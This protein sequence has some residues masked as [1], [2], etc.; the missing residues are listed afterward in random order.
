MLPPGLVD[1][2]GARVVGCCVFGSIGLAAAWIVWLAGLVVVVVVR[3]GGTGGVALF[4]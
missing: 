4:N 2:G 3:A 1:A